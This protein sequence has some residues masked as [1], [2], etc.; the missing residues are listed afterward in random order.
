MPN[1]KAFLKLHDSEPVFEA[2]K[3]NGYVGIPVLVWE[4]GEIV[5]KL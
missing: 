3:A 2:K 5:F 4:N 1:L